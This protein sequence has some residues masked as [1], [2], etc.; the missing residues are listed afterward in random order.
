MIH[1]TRKHTIVVATLGLTGLMS[2]GILAAQADQGSVSP[3][4]TPTPAVSSTS[5][6]DDNGTD[7]PATHDLLDDNGT[8][9][10]ATPAPAV[11]H[12]AGDDSPS[13]SSSSGSNTPGSEDSG[14]DD[15]GSGGNSGHSGGSDDS[16]SDHAHSSGHGSD[17]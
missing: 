6:V 5:P 2:L 16:G 12:S 1:L 14:S 9:N 11:A 8:D 17:D 3:T 13:S 15:S 7:D 10:P 4:S